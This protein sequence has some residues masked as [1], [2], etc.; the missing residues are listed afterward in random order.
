MHEKLGNDS[1]SKIEGRIIV[2]PL[3]R[4]EILSAIEE[5]YLSY[6]LSHVGRRHL[7]VVRHD[8]DGLRLVVTQ[9]RAGLDQRLHYPRERLSTLANDVLAKG[10]DVRDESWE[11]ARLP[12]HPVTTP[13]G[14]GRYGLPGMAGVDAPGLE[15]LQDLGG[16]YVGKT[17]VGLIE[18]S[19]LQ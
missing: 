17:R 8:R 4:R 14:L 12:E 10:Q 1:P 15:R 5:V 11:V 19:S 2:T 18:T 3:H 13:Q 9:E 7:H 6:S 16:G